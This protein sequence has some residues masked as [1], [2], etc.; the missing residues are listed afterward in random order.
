[1]KSSFEHTIKRNKNAI[2]L[3]PGIDRTSCSSEMI[4]ILICIQRAAAYETVRELKK[5]VFL[6]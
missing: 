6:S 5:S 2:N 4:L 3:W 1:M